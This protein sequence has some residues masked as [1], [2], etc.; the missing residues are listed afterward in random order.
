[1]PSISA[2]SLYRYKALNLWK[3]ERM[4]E[5][6]EEQGRIRSSCCLDA[7][8]HEEPLFRLVLKSQVSQ[9][10]LHSLWYSIRIYMTVISI[11]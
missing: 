10:I 7:H 1:M 4:K 6:D 3:G 2:L 9:F 5:E 8:A 11:F